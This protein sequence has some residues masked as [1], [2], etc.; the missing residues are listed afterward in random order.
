MRYAKLSIS[1]LCLLAIT[2]GS[3]KL[4]RANFTG[5]AN[6]IYA[7]LATIGVGLIGMFGLCA[8][9]K[10]TNQN[11]KKIALI[12]GSYAQEFAPSSG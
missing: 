11:D 2:Y 6:E 4:Y 12:S 3:S 9:F 8:M 10:R 1:L 5:D 7:P